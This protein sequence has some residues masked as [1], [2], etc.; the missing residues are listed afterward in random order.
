M[1]HDDWV[2]F[3]NIGI[4]LRE[5]RH[6]ETQA[7]YLSG[8]WKSRVSVLEMNSPTTISHSGEGKGP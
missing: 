2:V 7:I 5:L 1:D 6:P 4:V 3:P 8:S